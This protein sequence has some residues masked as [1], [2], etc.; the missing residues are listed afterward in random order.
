MHSLAEAISQ[1]I[2]TKD[3][4][5][6]FQREHLGG[7]AGEIA[8]IPRPAIVVGWPSCSMGKLFGARKLRVALDELPALK[9]W[10][11]R[12]A[13]L[14]GRGTRSVVIEAGGSRLTVVVEETPMKNGGAHF[15]VPWM[16]AARQ[17]SAAVW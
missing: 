16:R 10:S 1:T 4:A 17:S 12:N 2:E 3:C 11:L 5:H 13:E 7:T 14:I 15:P 6:I 9:V 8:S